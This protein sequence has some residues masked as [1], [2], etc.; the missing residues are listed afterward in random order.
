MGCYTAL[1]TKNGIYFKKYEYSDSSIGIS[2]NKMDFN[3]LDNCNKIY[4]LRISLW[5]YF[6]VIGG[7]YDIVEL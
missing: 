5:R 2:F 3:K 4:F 7:W 6:I 1:K